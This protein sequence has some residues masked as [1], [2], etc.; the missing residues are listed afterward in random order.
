MPGDVATIELQYIEEED[1]TDNT[2]VYPTK[3]TK[4]WEDI[5][6]IFYI[7]L[8]N[9][10]DFVFD[11]LEYEENPFSFFANI[12]GISTRPKEPIVA[13]FL[14]TSVK[15]EDSY[16][17]NT[18]IQNLTSALYSN[19]KST[20]FT[21][22]HVNGDIKL[23]F[24]PHI[25]DKSIEKHPALANQDAFLQELE[26]DSTLYQTH[27]EAVLK[28][29]K[30]RV[31]GSYDVAFARQVHLFYAPSELMYKNGTQ[32]KLNPIMHFLQHR[33][34]DVKLLKSLAHLAFISTYAYDGVAKNIDNFR[35]VSSLSGADSCFATQVFSR[36]LALLPNLVK[37]EYDYDFILKEYKKGVEHRIS[38][39][40]GDCLI[41]FTGDCE[42]ASRLVADIWRATASV[43]ADDVYLRFMKG[44]QA[45]FDLYCTLC[46]IQTVSNMAHCTCILIPI[47]GKASSFPFAIVE[48]TN[49]ISPFAATGMPQA[50][51][52]S[53]DMNM[54]GEYRLLHEQIMKDEENQL[55]TFKKSWKYGPEDAFKNP[56]KQF[57]VEGGQVG[58]S[59][60]SN[61]DIDWDPKKLFF[62]S[63]KPTLSKMDQMRV[64]KKDASG[65]AESSV[66]WYGL[67]HE[68]FKI[69]AKNPNA[70]PEPV[71]FTTRDGNFYGGS[72]V[73]MKSKDFETVSLS[74]GKT[75]KHKN[76][77]ENYKKFIKWHNSKKMPFE[78][79][80]D[81]VV[82]DVVSRS[83]VE[84]TSIDKDMW[85]D[86][87]R[88]KDDF[89]LKNSAVFGLPV[90]TVFHQTDNTKPKFF[91]DELP[92]SGL[93]RAFKLKFKNRLDYVRLK[94]PLSRN[95]T[96]YAG[97]HFIPTSAINVNARAPATSQ[98]MATYRTVMAPFGA[99]AQRKL[100]PCSDASLVAAVAARYQQVTGQK[101]ALRP[102]VDVGTLIR[103]ST[104]KPS[105]YDKK[106]KVSA[107]PPA[108]VKAHPLSGCS[109]NLIQAIQALRIGPHM[110]GTDKMQDDSSYVFRNKS[111]EDVRKS[112]DLANKVYSDL[113][114]R[115][116][117]IQDHL[118]DD[119]MDHIEA[120]AKKEG[121]EKHPITLAWKTYSHSAKTPKDH[122]TFMSRFHHI[123]DEA[124]NM[125]TH[126]EKD[127]ES[128]KDFGAKEY[129]KVR[130][131]LKRVERGAGKKL[132]EL[133]EY[134]KKVHEKLVA[135]GEKDKEFSEYLARQGM[136]S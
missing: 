101:L 106:Q 50:L 38:D 125:V 84:N 133:K 95:V 11:S 14:Q 94:I 67:F 54:L 77:I 46:T 118:H 115:G 31:L 91:F 119:H 89:K 2:V 39:M 73:E 102:N 37:Y 97:V 79:E 44:V 9:G 123:V 87:K 45:Q 134:A 25:P 23:E 28:K 19:E 10:D 74:S 62:L 121:N 120:F 42:D 81:K 96:I 1:N 30:P 83:G 126:S 86:Y 116:V 57:E 131:D 53:A 59:G 32:V 68:G 43:E 58:Q 127:I 52:K 75:E 18:G 41:N 26:A 40:F 22:P 36:Y 117:V 34:F 69:S 99:A 130:D 47:G 114:T 20:K 111:A 112:M 92:T 78:K 15:N 13:F 108:A 132:S 110:D 64:G 70:P 49:A 51:A 122:D 8:E 80:K 124:G 85:D 55:E 17:V 6:F 27:L 61:P 60:E 76:C 103:R 21:N 113:S 105:E 7:K 12:N 48:G 56:Y 3:C 71:L 100:Y 16:Y 136:R 35:V 66:S 72:A 24:A 104:T 90:F 129:D 63:A 65:R 33:T 128:I 135:A 29:Y 5:R 88:N 107:Q 82:F 93:A 109:G 98:A 4:H